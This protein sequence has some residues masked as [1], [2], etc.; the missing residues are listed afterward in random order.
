MCSHVMGCL[1]GGC[2]LQ[3]L[4]LVHGVWQ[5]ERLNTLQQGQACPQRHCL[6]MH[7]CLWTCS[8]EVVLRLCLG[9]PS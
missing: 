7:L 3:L 2:R 8:T 5:Q 4:L 9:S 6:H 1:L